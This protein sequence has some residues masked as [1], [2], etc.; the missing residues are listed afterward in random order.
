MKLQELIGQRVR[1][2][3][4]KIVGKKHSAVLLAVSRDG[5]MGYL[6]L[7]KNRSKIEAH[8]HE[9]SATVFGVELAHRNSC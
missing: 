4:R 7:T 3:D 9:I 6:R 2:K 5:S 1:V 8:S